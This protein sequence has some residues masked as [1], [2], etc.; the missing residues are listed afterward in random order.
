MYSSALKSANKLFRDGDLHG[1]ESEY[2]K[3]LYKNDALDAIVLWNLSRIDKIKGLSPLV[4]IKSNNDLIHQSPDSNVVRIRVGP[5]RNIL[6][7]RGSSNS[8]AHV[9]V[10]NYSDSLKL[11]IWK[12]SAL[13]H[14]RLKEITTFNFDS[15]SNADFAI[16]LWLVVHLA[17]VGSVII[18]YSLDQLNNVKFPDDY[19]S[20]YLMDYKKVGFLL[21]SSPD[22]INQ[23]ISVSFCI[24]AGG[25]NL[26]LRRCVRRI[27]GFNI[28]KEIIICGN[29]PDTFPYINQVKVVG[30]DIPY[31]P[32]RLCIKKNVA[33]ESSN[34]S[35]VCVIHDRILLPHDFPSLF[36]DLI[37]IPVMAI[38]GIFTLDSNCEHVGRYSDFNI[39]KR[40]SGF[41]KVEY[42]SSKDVATPNAFSRNSRFLFARSH[43]FSYCSDDLL[44][45][46]YSYAT[47]SFFLTP[48][49]VYDFAKLDPGF[50]WE[51]YEDVQWAIRTIDK[52]IPHVYNTDHFH[53]T[54]L[55]RPTILPPIPLLS[56]SQD[57]SVLREFVDVVDVAN[58]EISKN[59]NFSS[60]AAL[61]I[62]RLDNFLLTYPSSG[63]SIERFRS[64][65]NQDL[66]LFISEFNNLLK[67]IAPSNYSDIFVKQLEKLLGISF[68]VADL[69]DQK[70]HSTYFTNDFSFSTRLI[71]NWAY[72]QWVKYFQ[73]GL[74]SVGLVDFFEDSKDNDFSAIF[75]R[76]GN[77]RRQLNYLNKLFGTSYDSVD[78]FLIFEKF[79]FKFK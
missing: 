18:P 55:V 36:Q 8:E 24:P 76:L 50:Y 38:G 71:N 47:G 16:A 49:K 65:I 66:S 7:Y 53:I 73:L 41:P 17:K 5:T 75:L 63:Y 58:F 31:P 19:Y 77:I 6:F 3:L 28:H 39:A 30:R 78:W 43:E 2:K 60:W 74:I 79:K 46:G 72:K 1:A 11:S 20:Q 52:L 4:N 64:L 44:D 34:L 15:F 27:L 29:I 48:R 35:Y 68:E 62:S 40:K 13:D 37:P 59:N 45:E 56:K 69:E 54:Q 26:E 12:I 25:D 42:I 70:I 61:F 57:K 9:S 10:E 67:L 21:V 14:G 33:I 23:P 22:L 32:L 51:D